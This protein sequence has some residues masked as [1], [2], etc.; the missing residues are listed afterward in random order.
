MRELNAADDDARTFTLPPDGAT[1]IYL[2]GRRATAADL[3]PGQP[4]CIAFADAAELRPHGDERAL[5]P[6]AIRAFDSK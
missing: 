5:Y 4:L 2:N 6:M 1:F 3:R